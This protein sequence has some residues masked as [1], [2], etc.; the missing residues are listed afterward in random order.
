MKKAFSLAEV[1][2]TLMV[3]GVVAALTIPN[4]VQSYKERVTVS[5]LK[6]THA[7]LADA[8]KYLETELGPPKDWLDLAG[9]WN[10]DVRNKAYPDILKKRLIV[11]KDCG[12]AQDGCMIRND[13]CKNLTG[14]N[15]TG[16]NI[17]INP[18]TSNDWIWFYVGV[19][20]R[21]LLKNGVAIA[22]QSPRQANPPVFFH[23]NYPTYSIIAVDLNNMDGPNVFGR[24]I[25]FFHLTDVGILPVGSRQSDTKGFYKFNSYCNNTS[26][27]L[28]NG[29]AC[30]AY[31]LEKGNMDYLRKK[32]SW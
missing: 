18:C 32:V 9:E 3:I 21:F 31:V 26:Q 14:V 19:Y 20:N 1:L 25:F 16:T 17:G 27:N 15:V 28:A 29:V 10:P 4:L 24:D 7:I 22:M 23:Q 30:A 11:A 6:Q 8:F 12:I 2:T 5:K 13:T